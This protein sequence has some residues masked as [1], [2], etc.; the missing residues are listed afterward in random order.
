MI[1]AAR[2]VVN[3]TRVVDHYEKWRLHEIN[4]E[5]LI[6]ADGYEA[7]VKDLESK[8]RED[9]MNVMEWTGPG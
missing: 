9:A 8:K 4:R 5:Q 3:A 1:D 6:K 7:R 2:R